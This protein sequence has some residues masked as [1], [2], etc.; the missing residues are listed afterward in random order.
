MRKVLIGLAA[1]LALA[2]MVAYGLLNGWFVP[3]RTA[4]QVTAVT[5]PH[6]SW[7]FPEGAG[8]FPTLVL[9]HGC[10]GRTPHHDMWAEVAVREGFAVLITDSQTG[11]GLAD[12][13][14]IDAVCNLRALTAM[15]RSADLY[16]ALDRVAAEPKADASNVLLMGYSHGGWTTL[17][18][19]SVNPP[20][21]D[22][23]GLRDAPALDL[24]G[25]KASILLYPYCGIGATRHGVNHTAPIHMYL[26]ELDSLTAADECAALADDLRQQG[27]EVTDYVYKG[28]EHAFDVETWGDGTANKD[29]DREQQTDVITRVRTLLRLYR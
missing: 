12:E 24:Q 10:G 29:F 7:A 13:A 21:H 3:A 5:A 26:A 28:A 14:G 11:R 6:D 23:P 20:Q 9:A 27:I 1:L 17:D 25:V 16:L 15:E 18:L 19:L 8:P 22:F 4:A 2:A